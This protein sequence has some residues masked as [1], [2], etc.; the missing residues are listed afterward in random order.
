MAKKYLSKCITLLLALCMLFCVM[1]PAA[2]A[3]DDNETFIVVSTE[4]P[5]SFN[6]D[7]QADD[8]GWPMFQ[9]IFDGLFQLNWNN[10]IVNDLCET[11]DISDDGLTYTFHLRKGVK[12]HDGEPF[13]SA[14]V[15]FTYQMI[16]DNSGVISQELNTSVAEMSCPDDDTFVMVLNAPNA[17]IL[18]T[19]AW[20][21]NFIIPKHL[22]EG[23]ED[24]KTCDAAMNP[25]GTGA[26]KF[27]SYDRGVSVVLEKNPDYHLGAPDPERLIFQII[28]DSDTALQA[29][30]NGEVDMV[31][32]VP[33][34]QVPALLQDPQYKMGYSSAAR[35][36]QIAM[37]ME[38]EKMT[39]EVRKAVAL[40]IDREEISVKGT[41]SLMPPAY[42]FY[43]PY[44]S[45]AYNED[46]DIG[47][48]DVEQARSLLE[49]AGYTLN[50]DGYYLDL[51]LL[52]FTG[53]SYADCG[54]VM[55]SNLKDAGINLKLTVL[56]SAAWND[57]VD[58][59]DFDMA[60]LNGYQ[61]PDPD[62]MSKRV[63]TGGM[64]NYS[65][66]S[67]AEVD[68]LLA[69]ARSLT[70]DEERGECYRRIQEIEAEELPII[71]VV[72]MTT[73][74]ICRSNVSGIPYVDQT[75]DVSDNSYAKV[76]IE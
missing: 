53:G 19:L 42:G 47:E 27:V 20:Y 57:R 52:V 30:F 75:P 35:R 50:D 1:A 6:P 10:E 34:S 16:M 67:N 31:K 15:Q 70:K 24:W 11:Y 60:M 56:E 55:Q 48:R 21:G 36:Y 44:C 46:A 32:G 26:Y 68:E 22:Y 69:K 7:A 54:K 13:T 39:W 29:F 2:L 45:W 73:Y 43:P 8:I 66:Y 71:P 38:S 5:K 49:Q 62:A 25:V 9:N 64:A 23:V 59:G 40:S 61:G 12:W 14:D 65:K 28:P 72:E 37:N 76:V 4:D 41:N 63:G 17:P 58:N 74:Y 3:D 33:S 18:G 51:E